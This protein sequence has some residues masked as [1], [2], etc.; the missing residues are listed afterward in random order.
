MAARYWVG[1]TG[2][3]DNTA[4][5]KWALTSG[6]AGGQA[7]PTTADDVF[8]DAN[9]GAN[10]VT[11]GITALTN[12]LNMTG[13]TGTLAFGTNKIQIAYAGAVA[14]VF[15]GNA[16]MSVTGTP[17]IEL[18]GSGGT[19]RFITTGSVTE[20]NSISFNI[21]SGTERFGFSNGSRVRNINFTG[22]SGIFDANTRTIYGNV[23]LSPTMT[24]TS[25]LNTSWAATSG[26]QTITS[27]GTSF[28][29]SH[30]FDGV[31]GTVQLADAFTTSSS[32]TLNNGTFNSNGYN[33]TATTFSSN[34][35]NTRT[36]TMGSSTWTLSA[37][38]PWNTAT[39]TGL[40][41]NVNTSQINLS[42]E[43]AA[44]TGGGLTFNNVSFTGTV[45]YG[46][47]ITDANTFNNLTISTQTNLTLNANQ[48][49]TGTFTCSGTSGVDRNFVLSNTFAT[50]RTLTVATLSAN[51]CN[52][53]D[54][55]IAGAAAGAAPTR[56]G[57]CGGNSGITFP[58]AKT[59][60]WNLAGSQNFTAN[61][62]ATTSN[63]TPAVNNYPLPQD[64][65]VFT[66]DGA[67]GTITCGD[68]TNGTLPQIDL[69]ARTSSM[70]I[71]FY[72]SAGQ[73]IYGGFINSANAA[74]TLT[75]L[76]NGALTF[77]GRKSV[78]FSS[79]GRTIP[80]SGVVIDAPDGTV[81]LDGNTTLNGSLTV[82]RGTFNTSASNYNLTAT[83]LSSNN[84]NIRTIT[85]NG[86]T[87][88][89]SGTGTLNF[90]TSTNLT[91]N[92]GTSTI[93]STSFATEFF[94]GGR[95]F[96]N[97]NIGGTL[98]EL[99][100]ISGA[101]TFN[102]LT[103]VNK[104][105]VGT[106]RLV[107]AANQ[108]VNGTFTC[109]GTQT[110]LASRYYIYSSVLGTNRTITAAAI[111]ISNTDFR[112][113]TG[114]GAASWS[115]SSRTNYWGNAGGNSG[116][117]FAT[118]RS[119]YWN[120]AGSQN[121]TSTAWALT[122][123]GTPAA[124][125]YPLI[126][127]TATFTEAGAAGTVTLDS[128]ILQIPTITMA[129]GVSNRTS[130]MTLNFGAFDVDNLFGSIT[131]FSN[132]TIT[133]G[134]SGGRV[135]R[136]AG[137]GVTQNVTSAGK[138][139][140]TAISMSESFNSTVTLQDTFTTSS[141][142]TFTVGTLNLNNNT[143][144]AFAFSSSNSNPRVI[145]F[146]TGNITCTG[147][148]TTNPQHICDM[149]TIT[150]LSY[151]GTPNI[152]I[153]NNSATAASI[154][155]GNNGTTS[156][157]ALDVNITTG[158]YALNING[159]SKFGSLNFTG[160]AGSWSVGGQ[161]F[162]NFYRNLTLSSEMSVGG[163]TTP[164][165][166]INTSGT[167]IL[168][169]A[170]KT[171][172][173]VVREGSGGTLQLADNLTCNSPITLTSG[174][175]N[176]NNKNVTCTRFSS[177]NSNTRTLTMGSGTWTLSGTGTVWDTSTTT[178]LTFNRDTANIVLSNTT[179]TARTFAGG[180]LTYNNLTIGGATG[181]ST[182]T[183]EGA[184]TFNTLASTK[185]VA[186]TIVFP[187]VTTTVSNWTIKGTAGNIVTL[188]RTGGSGTF[189]LAKSGGVVS[190]VDYLSISNSTASPTNIWYA[191]SNSTDGGGNTNWLFTFAPSFFSREGDLEKLFV[192][193][194]AM[195]DQYAATGSLW[196]WGRGDFGQLGDN[197]STAKSS[198]VQTVSGG[199]NWKL[200]AGGNYHAA[201]IK[202][203]GT[204]WTWGRNNFGQL[205]DNTVTV[206]SSPVQT[207][208]SGTNWKQV[209]AGYD[210]TAAIKTDGTL[211][212][213]GHNLFGTLGDNTTAAK[214][215]PVQTVSA[216]TNWKQVAGGGRHTAAIK[217]DGTL[218]LWGWNQ[219]GQLA[220]N[221]I[222]H[223][224]SPI[225][226][227]SG[228]TNWKLVAA[229]RDHTAAIKTDGTLW[230]WGGNVSGQ[231]GDGSS[232]VHRSSPIQTVAGGTNWKLVN[233]GNRV[234][235]AIKTDGTLWLW[236]GNSQGELGTDTINFRSSPVQ[237]VSGG[238]NWKQVSCGNLY[239]SAIKTDGTLWTWGYNNTGQL[240]DNT[241]TSRSS[242]VQTVSGG[243]N[244][245]LVAAGVYHAA[246][247][248]FYEAG[249]L[250]PN[251]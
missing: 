228:G 88:T 53:R 224:S 74:V 85:L 214:S 42:N 52:F 103:I 33:V 105:A 21:T 246:A 209:A 111:S 4:G 124:T 159:L 101:N 232:V 212:L 66:N 2:T 199:T 32:I 208:S 115:D 37:A 183:I 129:D 135:T 251:S 207:V 237:T 203:D 40:T 84:S 5:T 128:Q 169:S 178:G 144:S 50:A 1:G 113:I 181:T 227:V 47:S 121:W 10:T 182:L 141:I 244:W 72:L 22:F 39:T 18:T 27:N 173:S 158:T 180:G 34:N 238:T 165:N 206:R 11:I 200:V 194:Y 120:L 112:N 134:G 96:Y 67:A 122:N 205:G 147:S 127:D 248:H 156:S 109:N 157:N 92:A 202:T 155:I 229:G 146:G 188:S 91:F 56:A 136:F 114:A 94:G 240:G 45:G 6:G 73:S 211:W 216:G 186:H 220:D 185:T 30:S 177:S 57:D 76:G 250:Y 49:I 93:T 221:S 60:Y 41:F 193:D 119:V 58:A 174:T 152:N 176:A 247:I 64:I 126:Q 25:G 243:T 179:T 192:T 24:T 81:T 70:T 223:R 226:T 110:V 245:K 69:S 163:D 61:G 97:V 46:R 184:N 104:S 139:F 16:T 219:Y 17:L 23:V 249:N 190:G 125:N 77:R 83:S 59:V 137:Y 175:F 132:L 87:V 117:T 107:L 145:Q 48:T 15:T 154:D 133:G 149:R 235:A 28:N 65:A 98:S 140:P 100:T 63:G 31:G 7:V 90:T 38:A 20:A 201:S 43:T 138:T 62:W 75:W 51:D 164:L 89:L 150:S 215:S 95:T 130:A 197:T 79:A 213:W 14:T 230:L 172:S 116:I 162:Y 153:S 142:F 236:G 148:G 198:P 166:F 19:Q 26:T 86:S 161:V 231:L 9:S 191:G 204:L 171:L 29:G 12:T 241:R 82:T 233:V 106:N 167:S 3:W 196:N 131:L 222:Q 35:S 123:N 44:F 170:G 225:Q 108:T 239:T 218:W 55:T 242:P 36:L 68:A 80:G 54:I 168:T 99:H 195:I 71:D 8:F 217:T 78:T 118:G 102:N 210:H 13:F 187:N 160:F 143:L 189:T 234:T 151:T